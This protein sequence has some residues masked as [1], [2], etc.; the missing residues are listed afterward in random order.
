[1]IGHAGAHLLWIPP[2]LPYYDLAGPFKDAAG[3]SKT[4]VFSGW[5]MVPRMIATLLSYEVERRTVGNPASREAREAVA[6]KY[7]PPRNKPNYRRHPVPLLVFR[8]EDGEFAT[9]KNMSNF[10]C[11]YPSPSLAALYNPLSP[12]QPGTTVET[13]RMALANRFRELISQAKLAKFED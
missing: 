13:L 10:C 1:S 2:N 11:L 4:L 8:S 7:F 5:V 6:R 12:F 3:F 9:A